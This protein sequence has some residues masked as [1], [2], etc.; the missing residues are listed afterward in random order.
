M[1]EPIKSGDRCEV[2]GAV[3]GAQSPN[4]GKIVT[5]ASLQGEHSVHGRIWRCT[6]PDLITEYGVA[7][8]AADFAAS[9]LRKLPDDA[10]G[11]K[12]AL[13]LREAA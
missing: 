13:A 7:G 6:A 2:I 11:N 5:V 8:I 3:F 1:S 12:T 4:L 10:H 9:W